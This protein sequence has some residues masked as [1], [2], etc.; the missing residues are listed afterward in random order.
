MDRIGNYSRRHFNRLVAA[1]ERMLNAEAGY[2]DEDFS[3]GDDP[4]NPAIAVDGGDAEIPVPGGDFPIPIPIPVIAGNVDIPVPIPVVEDNYDTNDDSMSSAE[5]EDDEDEEEVTGNDVVTEEHNDSVMSLRTKLA[6]FVLKHSLSRRITNDL[7]ALWREEG[8]SLPKTR[9]TL[10]RTT[11]TKIIPRVCYPGEYHHFGLDHALTQMNLSSLA[12]CETIVL[13][14]GI[15][16][17]SL[18]K[19]SKLKIWPILGAF[20]SSLNSSPFLIGAYVGNHDPEDIDNF[21]LDL[22]NELRI[23]LVNGVN[24]TPRKINKPLFIRCFVCDSPAR[25]FLAGV[26]GHQANVGCNKCNQ[27]CV[28]IDGKKTYLTVKGDPRTD[29]TF[30]QRIHLDHHKDKFKNQLSLLETLNIGMVSQVPNDPMHLVDEG[31]MARML[32]SLFDGPCRSGRLSNEQKQDLDELYVSFS[33]YVPTEFERKPRSIIHELC[34]WK[35]VEFRFFLNYAACVVLKDFVTPELYNHFLVLMTAVRWLSASGTYLEN[36]TGAQTLIELFVAQYPDIYDP[37]ELAYN[38]HGLLHITE[39]VSKF[40]PLY[41]YSAYRYENHMRVIRKMIRKPNQIIQQ[42]HKRSSEIEEL[43][44]IP[45][46]VG[47]VGRPRPFDNDR[48]PECHTSYKGFRFDAFVLNNNIND[49]A[50]M[51]SNGISVEVQGFGNYNGDQVIFARPYVNIRN[52][53]TYPV[54]SSD[55]LGILQV[56]RPIDFEYSVYS[57]TLVSYKYVK[58]PY[59]RSL[60][61]IPMLHHIK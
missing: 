43:N 27:H 50:C 29:E 22:V 23:L 60:I 26:Y 45:E 32:K 28:R 56:D 21:L 10:V 42:L 30:K 11:R 4:I 54:V 25:S 15:D 58:L 7:L 14:I 53:F 33:V 8:Y 47:F 40:G 49:N 16:G 55:G 38:I 3:D 48:F 19:S 2:G 1:D 57:V 41:S 39:D 61:L 44:K 12:E 37:T 17:L 52:F 6:Q 18:S 34:R 46:E 35:A 9:E 24:V 59:H 51:L 31:A 20:S 36:L 5:D 13:D